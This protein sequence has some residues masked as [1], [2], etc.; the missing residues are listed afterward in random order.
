[1]GPNIESYPMAFLDE[2]LNEFWKTNFGG[3]GSTLHVT[4]CEMNFVDNSEGL[5]TAHIQIYL[6]DAM[7]CAPTSSPT[8]SPSITP[9]PTIEI[10]EDSP[11]LVSNTGG[12]G[13]IDVVQNP[14]F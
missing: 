4:V 11:L 12:K 9:S 6:D 3:T 14:S 2:D 5:D 10:C 1:M 8:K 7:S 13:C